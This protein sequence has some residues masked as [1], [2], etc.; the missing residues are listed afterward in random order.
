MAGRQNTLSQEGEA[1]H[2]LD[3]DHHSTVLTLM[4]TSIYLVV[5]G[6][7]T[8]VI[9][10]TDA[11][12]WI[13]SK[14]IQSFDFALPFPEHRINQVRALP[15]VLWAQKLFLS[16]GFLKLANGGTIVFCMRILYARNDCATSAVPCLAGQA[17]RSEVERAN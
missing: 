9:R 3:R 14:N 11:D 13:A 12:I 2:N 6:D 8:A 16:W 15:D 17:C 1:D 10:N 5:M 4:E 7:A